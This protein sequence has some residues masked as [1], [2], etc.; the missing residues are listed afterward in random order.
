MFTGSSAD[1]GI[2]VFSVD[3]NGL[4]A[5]TD[6]F[7]DDGTV[8]LQ[9]VSSLAAAD[10]GGTSY[11]FAAGVLDNGVSVF[12][13]AANGTLTNIDNVT[14]DATLKIGGTTAVE[15]VSVGGTTYL[16]VAGGEG[17]IS[18]FSVAANGTLTNV[19]NVSDT[20]TR[21]LSGAWTLATATVGGVTYVYAGSNVEDGI[22]IFS[23]DASGTLTDVGT[24]GDDATLL[25]NGLNKLINVTIGGVQHI[26]AV[27]RVDDGISLFQIE[28]DG[29]LLN[30]DNIR[31]DTTVNLNS[32]VGIAGLE[33][34]N[35][36]YL[37]SATPVEGSSILAVFAPNVVEGTAGPETLDGTAGMDEIH[38]LAGD[39]E[40]NGFGDDDHLDG[41]AGDDVL[42]G[43]AGDDYLIG[44]ADDDV[45]IGGPGS[46]ILDGGADTD[47]ASYEDAAAGIVADLAQPGANTGDAAGDQYI[48][49]E[50]LTGSAFDDALSGDG[51][52][53]T[54]VGGAGND[55]LLGQDGDDI[56]EG[57]AGDD[58]LEGGAGADTLL[59]GGGNNFASY[60]NAAGGVTVNLISPGSNTGD[61]AGD[62]YSSIQNLIGSAFDD[63]LSGTFA[64]NTINGGDG[65]DTLFGNTGDDT[66]SGEV[67]DD[68]LN[69][70][71]GADTLLGGGGSNTASY[72]GSSTGLTADLVVTGNNT[73]NAVGDTYNSIQNL[74]GSSF[75]DTLRGTFSGN[76]I[77]G[78]DGNDFL[79]G[80]SGDDT[81]NGDGGDDRLDG[82]A[83]A[84]ALDGGTGANWAWY[85]SSGIGLTVSLDN[86][87]VNTG[88]A[89]GDSYVSIQNLQGSFFDDILTGDGNANSII[90]SLGND[91]V[92]GL[93]GDDTLSGQGGD[94]ILE[95]GAGADALQGGAG[96]DTASYANAGGS[97]TADL[98]LTGS[99]TGDASGDSFSNIQ[100]LTGS[101]F[102]DVLRGTF[103]ANVIDGGA[104]NDTLLGRGGGDTYTGGAGDDTFTFQNGFGLETIM[105]FDAFSA[106]ER[107]NL[108]SVTGITDFADLTANH[109]SDNGTDSFITDGAGT[110]TLLNVLNSDLDAGD[111]IF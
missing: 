80:R 37:A 35:D 111:F 99:N 11:L 18:V 40:L 69:G 68:T 14:D 5:N 22:T 26:A 31:D 76:T 92:F 85:L 70:G 75:N 25:L 17:G 93:G 104:G 32:V 55:N 1:N 33:F 63:D 82:G 29:T 3:A 81:L 44:G 64:A 94:D 103:A 67:G 60:A 23:I 58:T 19:D 20:P 66:L 7:S 24:V 78:G 96:T 83:G 34:A 51:N 106:G 2:S 28:D 47:T 9:A 39:D 59:G 71:P 4:L 54:I 21:L 89:A 91:E 101:G 16:L 62:T 57:R 61:A 38:G 87:A 6:N 50:N 74:S 46:D 65:N 105:D 36:T 8:N 52:A 41:G 108:G 56:L 95:G 109:L 98:I 48:A 13:V 86:A 42:N 73:G 110:I 53:N 72:A 77:S 90:S 27:G 10:V 84:D 79:L 107:I 97:I 88:D 30:I 49:I 43:G 12:S 100:N 15:T 45:L 102:D